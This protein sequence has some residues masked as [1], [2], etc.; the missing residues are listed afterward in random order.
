[1]GNQNLGLSVVD[2][3]CVGVCCVRVCVCMH[4]CSVAA[5]VSDSLGPYGL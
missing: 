3:V 2:A 1:M 4:V 5:F